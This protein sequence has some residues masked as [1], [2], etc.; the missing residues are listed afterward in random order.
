MKIIHTIASIEDEAAGPSYSVPSLAAAT[1]SLGEDVSIFSIGPIG[2]DAKRGFTH[3][4]FNHDYQATPIAKALSASR[5]MYRALLD[6][7]A[8]IIHNHGLWL[9]PNIYSA[10]VARKNGIPLIWAPRGML[11]PQALKFSSAKKFIFSKIFQNRAL[12]DVTLFHATSEQEYRDIRAY[13]LKQPVVIIPNGI[14]MPDLVPTK[15]TARRRLLFFGRIHPIKG[16]ENLLKA[17]SN[18]EKDFPD[19]DLQ[20]TGPGEP[21]YI[22]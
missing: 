4:R 17:W 7:P 8:D 2:Q 14:D 13:G 6:E 15:K 12:Q 19:W 3:K 18:I 1:A 22:A 16:L 21:Q 20:I 9:M 11:S 10:W 5:S